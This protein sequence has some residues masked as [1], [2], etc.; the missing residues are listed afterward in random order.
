MLLQVKTNVL[1]YSS[2][3]NNWN[4]VYQVHFNEEDVYYGQVEDG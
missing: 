1:V 2:D 4:A 3:L